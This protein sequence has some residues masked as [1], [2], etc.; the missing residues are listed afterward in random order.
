[1]SLIIFSLFFLFSSVAKKTDDDDDDDE[2]DNRFKKVTK[3]AGKQKSC[4]LFLSLFKFYLNVFYYFFFHI[5][6]RTQA[7]QRR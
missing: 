6:T 3:P 1:M 5:S 2:E 7:V 4:S